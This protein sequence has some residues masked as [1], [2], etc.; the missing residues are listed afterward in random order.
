MKK[1]RMDL[2]QRVR[3]ALLAGMAGAFLIPQVAFAA[4]TGENVVSGGATVTRSGSD[5]NINSSNANNVIKWSDYSLV[6]GERVVHD[7]GAKTN[8]YL[9]I[10]TGANTSNIDGKI[11]GGKNVYI[12]NPNGVIFGKNA[13]VNV[14]H[15]HVST[16]D[17][18]TVNTAADMANNVSP[19]S[20]T[21]HK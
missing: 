16:Q 4:P 8:N 14:G 21:A 17:T 10:V 9:N 2:S 7:G 11:E 6:H 5:T 20:T 19:L 3:Y 15:L 18:S 12:V 1:H 13:E